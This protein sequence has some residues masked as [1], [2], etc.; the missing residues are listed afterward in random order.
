MSA[1]EFRARDP[2]ANTVDTDLYDVNPLRDAFKRF[3]GGATLSFLDTDGTKLDS[4]PYGQ[5]VEVQ[6]STD[7]GNSWTTRFAG[8]ALTP[9]RTKRDGIPAVEVEI[10]AYSHLL[11]RKNVVADYSSTTRSTILNDLITTYTSVEW[12]ASLVTVQNDDSV[13]MTFRGQT[14]DQ[15][16]D[17]IA[18]DSAN[19][20]WGVNN[21]LKF[22]FRSG[23]TESTAKIVDADVIDYDLPKKGKR[24]INQYELYY[25]SGGSNVVVVNDREEQRELKDQLNAPRGVVISTSD[26]LPEITTR[27]RAEAIARQRLNEQSQIQTG[28][29]TVPLGRFD[30]EAGDI[31]PLTISDAGIT[32]VDF[33]IAQID[34]YW[35]RGEVELTIAENT[36][37]NV[38]ELLIGLSDQLTN[39]RLRDADPAASKTEFVDFR[40]GIDFTRETTLTAKTPNSGGITL[41]QS[42]LGQGTGDT[43]GAGVNATTVADVSHKATKPL[44]D[45]TRDLWIDGNSAFIDMTH[46]AVGTGTSDATIGDTSLDAEVGRV[47]LDRFGDGGFLARTEFIATIPP[48]GRFAEA[49]D[50]TE[51][52]VYDAASGGTLYDR[53]THDPVT[54]DATTTFHIQMILDIDNDSTQQGVITVNGQQRTRDLLIGESGHEPTDFVYGDGTADADPSDSSLGN[55]LY[56][57]T[58]DSTTDRETGVV[59]FSEETTDPEADTTNWSEIGQENAADELMSRVVFRPLA[60]DSVLIASHEWQARNN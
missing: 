15:A 11:T 19:E 59:L 54:I 50:L 60:E 52:G 58:I 26:H 13:D 35:L 41:G 8:V 57:D 34:Y 31:V 23:D 51:F 12:D 2:A 27:A 29:V 48:G 43:L 45:L 14:V 39:A 20:E 46:M 6:Y 38:E 32:A 1:I 40:S 28:T 36:G 22:F 5:R 55:K 25:G 49:G 30:T 16:V 10:V 56:E 33:R 7:S 3:A 53:I 47:E 37:G 4:Y 21:D 9:S 18:A 24:N 44:M 17:Q 42:E